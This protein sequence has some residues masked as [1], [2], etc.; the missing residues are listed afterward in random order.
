MP[1]LVL[2]I[3]I[4]LHL[5]RLLHTYLDFLPVFLAWLHTEDDR[6]RGVHSYGAVQR[7]GK[8]I[9]RLGIYHRFLVVF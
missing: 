8:P 7:P 9:R 3:V 6:L 5:L 4:L 1:S 2:F